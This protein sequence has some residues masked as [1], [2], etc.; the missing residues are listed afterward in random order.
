MIVQP[1]GRQ[2]GARIAGIFDQILLDRGDRLIV[3]SRVDGNRD[4][5]GE[6]SVV[7]RTGD[8]G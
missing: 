6:R 3:L 5:L 4:E 8:A 1:A 2:P 7:G